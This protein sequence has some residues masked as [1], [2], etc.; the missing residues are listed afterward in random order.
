[1]SESMIIRKKFNIELILA[2]AY[3][4]ITGIINAIALF[5]ILIMIAWDSYDG[6][7]I[8]IIATYTLC[9]ALY[10]TYIVKSIK[11]QII[12]CNIIEY[13]QRKL[14]SKQT[15][16]VFLAVKGILVLVTATIALL[17]GE[18]KLVFVVLPLLSYVVVNVISN[19]YTKLNIEYLAKLIDEH[20]KLLEGEK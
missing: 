10:I 6:I 20:K 3:L 18:G 12:N 4:V 8:C 17:T 11:S 14:I 2:S 19:Y 16:K 7:M 1:M 13:L 5:W 9:T 15:F